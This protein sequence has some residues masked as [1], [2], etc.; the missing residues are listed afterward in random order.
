MSI[1]L[2]A[3]IPLNTHISTSYQNPPQNLIN[4]QITKFQTSYK[5]AQKQ[6]FEQSN[7]QG[8]DKQNL[9]KRKR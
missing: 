1:F 7:F 6:N 8:D 4:Q 9:E 2:K 5:T 3:P